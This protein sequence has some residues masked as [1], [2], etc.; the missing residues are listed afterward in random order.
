MVWTKNSKPLNYISKLFGTNSNVNEYE[1][2]NIPIQYNQSIEVLISSLGSN[3]L[4]TKREESNSDTSIEEQKVYHLYRLTY[5][6]VL[7]VDPETPI[8]KEEYKRSNINE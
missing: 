3:I 4:T 8:A 7:I 5:D 1:V 2:D 6:K